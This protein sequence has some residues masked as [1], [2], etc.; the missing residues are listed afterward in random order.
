MIRF[1]SLWLYTFY[2]DSSWHT[3]NIPFQVFYPFWAY[4]VGL[5]M[6]VYL[7]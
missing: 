5:C 1:G 6:T 2:V 3:K 4:C 7:G